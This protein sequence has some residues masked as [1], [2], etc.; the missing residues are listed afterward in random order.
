V[1]E[2]QLTAEQAV[3]FGRALWS[4]TIT[5]AAHTAHGKAVRKWMETLVPGCLVV[6]ISGFQ[7]GDTGQRNP[8]EHQIGI[9]LRKAREPV[10]DP[11]EPD[12]EPPVIEFH[13]IQTPVGEM[14]WHNCMWVRVPR[15][16]DELWK[17]Q[18]VPR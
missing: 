5:A 2:F 10:R 6:A 11:D 8:W 4:I 7:N 16:A 13:Y 1:I 3:S 12:E 14:R 15:N 17:M 18:E 9:F